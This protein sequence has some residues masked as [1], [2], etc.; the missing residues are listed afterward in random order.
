MRASHFIGKETL[1]YEF[2][3]LKTK[4]L[5]GGVVYYDGQVDDARMCMAL[6]MTAVA[7]GANVCNHLKLVEMLPQEGCCRVVGVDDSITGD[8]VYIQAKAV[9]NATGA[10][11]DAVR[12]L[13]EEGTAPIIVPTLDTHV[14]LPRYFGSGRYGLLSPSQK[15]EDPTVVMVPFENHTVLGVYEETGGCVRQSPTPDPEDV[16]CLLDAAKEKMEPCVE[17]GRCHVLSAWTGVRPNVS[18][19]T[20][21]EEEEKQ[22]PAV[23]TYML[24]V[25][26]NGLI[27]LGGGRLSS[28]RVM[29]AEAVDLA[30]EVCGLCDQHVTHS[31]T[32]DLPLD[33]AKDWCCMLPWNSCRTTTC[34]WTWRSTYPTP[35]APT[36]T[37]CLPR[38]RIC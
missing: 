24:E 37:P 1:L 5:R 11:T 23:S 7:L 19:P 31:W 9:I 18:C 4:G 13:D 35:M 27:T 8:R 34:P 2:P 12:Q 6:V 10:G 17:L 14:S 26:E 22:S 36:A 21:K 30:I 25:S 33:G 28:Y 20:G 15:K 29:A 3:C 38:V 16:D 32:K